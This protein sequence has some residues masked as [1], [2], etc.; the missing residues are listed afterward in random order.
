MST[1]EPSIKE[2][3]YALVGIAV[4]LTLAVS[5]LVFLSMG[6]YALVFK[7]TPQ[8]FEL[9]ANTLG[10]SFLFAVMFALNEDF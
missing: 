6:V 3:A 1:K 9:V 10:F 7:Q 2:V 8:Y 5:F 4:Y